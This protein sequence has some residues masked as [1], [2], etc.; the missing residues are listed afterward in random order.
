MEPEQTASVSGAPPARPLVG[1]A[2]FIA[3]ETL[4]NPGFVLEPGTQ[5]RAWMDEFTARVPYRCLPLNM[6]NQAGW[7]VRTHVGFSVT[8]S[9]KDDIAALKISYMDRLSD[10]EINRL[11]GYIKSNFGDGIVTMLF[12]WLFRTP[13]GIGLWVHGPANT[14]VHNAQPLEGIVETDWACAPFTMNWKIL[15]RNDPAYFQKGDV[16]CMLTPFPLDLLESLRAEVRPIES[17]PELHAR[18]K[19]AIEERRRTFQR[20]IQQGEQGFELNYMRGQTPDGDRWA[21]HRTNLKL[22]AFVRPDEA[23]Q[24][25]A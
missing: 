7:V 20:A 11:G 15:K 5:R 3:Y 14:F 16:L 19:A 22:R 24:G 8:W 10:Q 2:A 4:P 6:A 1:E 13:P 12:P 9:G 17:D 25:G 18:Y 23:S 21:N